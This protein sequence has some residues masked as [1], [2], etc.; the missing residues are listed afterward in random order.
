MTKWVGAV[1][2]AVMATGLAAAPTAASDSPEKAES[3]S[4]ITV[5]PPERA[6]PP[7]V[8]AHP[9]LRLL[10]ADGR[11][12]LVSGGPVSP[13]RTCGGG[14]HDT[15][16]IAKYNYHAWLGADEDAY[17]GASRRHP[18]QVGT[19]PYAGWSPITYRLL[20]PG[21]ERFDLGTAEWVSQFGVRHAGGGPAVYGLGGVRLDSLDTAGAHADAH[22]L[23]SSSGNPVAWDWQRSGVAELNCFLCHLREPDND[24]RIQAL[25]DGRF[26]WAATATLERTGV[27]EKTDN[28][29][30]WRRQAFD[31]AGLAPE[32]RVQIGAPASV[33]CGQCHGLVHT[34]NGPAWPVYGTREWDT[35]T[36]GQVVS[37]QQMSRSAMNLTGKHTLGRP[38]DIHIASLMKCTNCHYL[39]ND[40]DYTSE[41]LGSRPAHL[42]VDTRR[43]AIG[44]Y[45]KRPLHQFVKGRSAQ[46]TVAGDLDGTM[47]RCE[48]C[49]NI[50]VTHAWLPYKKRHMERLLCESCHIPKVY[51][52]ARRATDWTVLTPD[53]GPRVEYRGID[54][55]IDDPASLIRGFRPALLPRSTGDNSLP[56][57]GPYNLIASWYW[58][59]SDPPRPVRV[60]DLTRVFFDGERYHDDIVTVFDADDDGD[61]AVAELVLDSQDKTAV[62]RHRLTSLGIENP[63]IVGEIQP[64]SLHHG[65]ATGKWTKRAC[66]SCHS[67]ESGVTAPFV[68]AASAPGGV[69]PEP[70]VGTN[71]QFGGEVLMAADGTITYRPAT[72][73][74]GFYVLGHDR[75]KWIDRTG[76]ALIFLVLLGVLVHGGLRHRYSRRTRVAK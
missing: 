57:L 19:G 73:D 23:D 66:E 38:W 31:A 25:E 61:I 60:Y 63:R 54:G 2:I 17:S 7:E 1:A 14:C 10:D 16:Y 5:P 51:A 42:N 9:R 30:W 12:V 8:I 34:G 6:G 70:V 56:R 36:K 55:P 11:D 33:N 59:Y 28:G 65:V 72:L 47:R 35:E 29:W 26:E 39:M 22:I 68:L 71:V 76:G 44:E 53:R 64:Y 43:Q 75:W 46:G 69:L 18:W 24:A 20:T 32:D 21:G 50:E 45:L 3:R 40:P 62:V 74:E 37:V 13:M 52:P 15:E 48:D 67:S 4:T 49:H 58:V 41:V 27:V